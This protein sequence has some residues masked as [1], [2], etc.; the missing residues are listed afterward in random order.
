LKVTEGEMVKPGQ[1]LVKLYGKDLQT[2]LDLT[3][4]KMTAAEQKYKIMQKGFRKEDIRTAQA[5]LQDAKEKLRIAKA[6][7]ERDK[8][9][10]ADTISAKQ[11]DASL[12]SFKQAEA[13]V[14]AM[15]AIFEKMQSGFREEEVEI[16]KAEFGESR[17]LHELAQRNLDYCT[18]KSPAKGPQLRV[19]KIYHRVGEWI[20]QDREGEAN[21]LSLYDPRNMQAR[22]DVIQSQIRYVKVG[23]KAVIKTDAVIGREYAGTVLRVEPQAEL[24]KNTITVRV[25]VDQPDELLFPDM[26]AQIS[27]LQAGAVVAK[28]NKNSGIQIP[29][30]ALLRNNSGEFVFLSSNGKAQRLP[31]IVL[32][33][34]AVNSVTVKGLASGQRIIVSQVEQLKDGQKIE[35]E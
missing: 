23:Q 6:H 8:K 17:S 35:E 27:F 33:G 22:V 28:Q 2:K 1:I 13:R 32:P 11:L 5:N 25:K 4:A 30:S 20:N 12:A 7:Y 9:M 24:A 14:L 19:L 21:I 18:I 26:T 3:R 16:A 15:I 31:V 29:K 10:G 34:E